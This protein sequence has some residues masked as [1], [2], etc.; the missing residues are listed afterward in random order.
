MAASCPA[1]HGTPCATSVRC[2]S[3]LGPPRIKSA[4]WRSKPDMESRESGGWWW[5]E[6]EEEA[7]EEDQAEEE[8]R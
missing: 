5:C 1:G 7:A 2:L 6:V 8:A 3:W 4:T